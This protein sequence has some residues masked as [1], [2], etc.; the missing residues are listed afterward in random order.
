MDILLKNVTVLDKKSDFHNK[1]TNVHI[2]NGKIADIGTTKGS[3]K[4]KIIEGKDLYVS[5]GWFDI[6]TRLTDPGFEDLDTI[7]SLSD[8]AAK[9]GYTG[10]AVFP[11]TSPVVDNKVMVRGII[12]RTNDKIVN[13]YPIGALTVDTNGK[14]IAEII[15]MNT[16]GAI[17]FSDGKKSINHGGVLSRALNYTSVL[18]A[19]VI[20]RP[21]DE[22]IS[23]LGV[24]NEG[25]M[26]TYLGMKGIPAIAE[27]IMLQRDIVLCKYND[28][29]LISHLISTE[30]SV[31]LI[32]E[33]KKD[34]V[35]VNATV[36]FHNLVSDESVLKN[37]NSMHKV[38]PPLRTSKDVNALIKGL[39]DGTI[40][41]I[42][43]NH[44]QVDIEEKRKA[45][46][47]T[48]YGAISLEAVFS[49]LNTALG[50][51]VPLE[52]LIDKLSNAPREI[53]GLE[54]STI[55]VGNKANLTVFSNTEE[56]KF[57]ESEIKS[58]SGNS[59]FINQTFIGK[60]LGIVNNKK[61]TL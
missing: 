2:V 55:A 27:S 61:S 3:D 53:L 46:F 32:K 18:D 11:N 15:D 42:V 14:D 5:P 35:N 59:P 33:A 41:A 10:L 9:G 60:V 40:D 28:S 25:E 38:L 36:S 58:K 57:E 50:K 47:D 23:E 6:G 22:N 21:N 20:N 43:S 51:K 34:K 4:S 45:F 26:S 1:T 13:F 12:D 48:K 17:A 54:L 56:Y 49:A 31:K 44:Y 16:N 8:S 29:H 19:P 52:T 24:I 39:K 30:N 7:D 37:F